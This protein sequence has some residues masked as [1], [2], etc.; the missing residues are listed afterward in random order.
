MAKARTSNG[1]R[2][3]TF[4]ELEAL[5]NVDLAVDPVLT[6]EVKG[7]FASLINLPRFRA[8][9]DKG[10][11]LGVGRKLVVKLHTAHNPETRQIDERRIDIMIFSKGIFRSLTAHQK[12][13]GA[14]GNKSWTPDY[15]DDPTKM[16][17]REEANIKNALENLGS[18]I[19]EGFSRED[20]EFIQKMIEQYLEIHIEMPAVEVAPFD[21]FSNNSVFS[22]R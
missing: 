17:S 15:T 20:Q 14:K 1:K 11:R 19:Y 5:L 9:V 21:V 3:T 10:E 7:N 8:H 22:V 16:S 13:A 2:K 4:S 6:I 12:T 18:A